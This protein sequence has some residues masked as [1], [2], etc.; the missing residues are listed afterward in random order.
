MG[1]VSVAR[2]EDSTGMIVSWSVQGATS[3]PKPRQITGLKDSLHAGKI[4]S[5][6]TTYF[7]ERK[8]NSH[9]VARLW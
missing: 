3:A 6:L 7:F 5:L 9:S 2:K 8:I 1:K 4:P